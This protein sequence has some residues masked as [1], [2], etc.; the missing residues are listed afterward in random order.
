MLAAA[1]NIVGKQ[2]VVSDLVPLFG[3]IP[4]PAD[5]LNE[6]SCVVDQHVIQSDNPLI[7]VSRRGILLQQFQA[8][9]IELVDIPV[10]LCQE[11]VKARRIGSIGE[12]YIDTRN[13][14]V[15][16]DHQTSEIFGEVLTLRLARKQIGELFPCFSND[17][18]KVDD[19]GHGEISSGSNEPSPNRTSFRKIFHTSCMH[20]HDIVVPAVQAPHYLALAS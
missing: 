8:T 16:S 20:I 12:F 17:V 19:R 15:S 7:V 1:G 11:A 6:L 9:L 14:L 10:H 18:W 3:M 4:E 2:I 5:I 13:G